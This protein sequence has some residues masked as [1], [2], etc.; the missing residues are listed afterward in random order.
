MKEEILRF[1]EAMLKLFEPVEEQYRQEKNLIQ[2]FAKGNI[3][4]KGNYG[5]RFIV[6][7]NS[8]LSPKR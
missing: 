7:L 4:K 2:V 5:Q 6:L 3:D 1:I 8:N